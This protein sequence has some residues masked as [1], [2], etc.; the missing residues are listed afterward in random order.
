MAITRKIIV[1]WDVTL[2]SLVVPEE[3]GSISGYF[4]P[5]DEGSWYQRNI[6]K[7]LSDYTSSDS[8][9]QFLAGG[10]LRSQNFKLHS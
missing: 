6:D 2:Y 10:I 4:C 8:R 9:R 7:Y 5:E 1:L 3:R